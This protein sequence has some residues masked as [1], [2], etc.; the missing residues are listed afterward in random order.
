MQ[1]T[2]KL[3]VRC[4]ITSELT[5]HWD[6]NMTS[7][8][9]CYM[10]AVSARF[11]RRPL[12]VDVTELNRTELLQ[13]SSRNVQH[14]TGVTTVAAQLPIPAVLGRYP[15]HTQPTMQLNCSV[16]LHRSLRG[17][18]AYFWRDN[19][20]II[21]IMIYIYFFFRRSTARTTHPIS[22]SVVVKAKIQRPRTR[23]RPGPSRPR[24]G[25]SR[26]RPRPRPGPF[27]VKTEAWTLKT[28]TK[29]RT[30]EYKTNFKAKYDS[31]LNANIPHAIDMTIAP[32]S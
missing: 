26:P 8:I 24:P 14:A 28:T 12:S 20:Y 32:I 27:K 29:A 19:G 10:S 15:P 13:L 18:L 9:V 25:A 31:Q 3:Q 16:Q 11:L 7:E 1:I 22:T 4:H 17:V 30:L 2:G 6:R 21:Y 23:P 5:L